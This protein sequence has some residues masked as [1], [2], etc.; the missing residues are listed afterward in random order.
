M[1]T[2]KN[3]ETATPR[4]FREARANDIS[5]SGP[6]WLEQFKERYGFV[7]R[8]AK[9]M[10]TDS[11]AMVSRQHKLHYLKR[12]HH[13]SDIYNADETGMFLKLTHDKTLKVKHVN[14]QA[15]K[16]INERITVM[17]CANMPVDDN[18]PIF[19]IG[20]FTKT[21]CFKKSFPTKY[22]AY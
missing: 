12:K 8:E 16:R 9:S 17:V 22:C 11:Q 4:S 13:T 2:V 15:G 14:C 10:K 19:V 3:L 18:L 7:S 21:R 6:E 20:K 5:V 1:T